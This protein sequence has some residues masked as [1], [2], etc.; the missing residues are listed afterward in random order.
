MLRQQE[1]SQMIWNIQN[2]QKR[3]KITIPVGDMSQ[4]RADERVNEIIAEYSEEITMDDASGQMLVNGEPKFNFQKTYVF[5]DRGGAA[6]GL[7]EVETAGYDM[8]TTES[9]QY[10]WRKFILET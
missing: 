4:A 1:N 3:M 7:E 2:A 9:L 10:F 8:H 6:V 5:D